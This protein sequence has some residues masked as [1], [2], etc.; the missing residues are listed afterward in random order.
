VGLIRLNRTKQLN[1]LSDALVKDITD[2]L[3]AFDADPHTGA[4]VITGS[5]KAFAAGADIRE[6]EPKTFPETYK[7]NMLAQWQDLSKIRKPVI[8]AVNGFA[9]GGGCELAMLCD[10]IVAG[11]N[12]VFGQPEVKLGTIPGCGGTQRLVRAVGKSKAMEMVL[13]GSQLSATEAAQSGLVSKVV[14][15]ADTVNEAVSIG[16]KI[17]A[18]SRPIIAMAKE[19]V[20]TAYETSLQQ[21]LAYERRLFHSTFGT[22]DRKEGM[23]AFIQKREPHWTHE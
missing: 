6:M 2:A 22:K 23:N 4:I 19:S 3:H 13:T 10:I 14:P 12:A 9:L 20:N 15:I 8:A 7:T 16:Q 1:A 18:L 17:A 21:G 5:D 11:D